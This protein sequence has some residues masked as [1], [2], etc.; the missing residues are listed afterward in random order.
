MTTT[1]TVE[2][3]KRFNASD[4]G[5]WIDGVYGLDH[6]MSKLAIM[7]IDSVPLDQNN[8]A[9]FPSTN[10]AEVYDVLTSGNVDKLADD[11]GEFNDATEYLESVTTDGLVWIWDAG[12]LILT[13]EDQIDV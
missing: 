2:P 3:I 4:V 5:C 7:L 9:S 1:Q 12:D 8:L 13:T 11:H 10:L 6:A